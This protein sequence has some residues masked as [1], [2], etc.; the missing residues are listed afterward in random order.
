[1]KERVGSM[2]KNNWKNIWNK[3]EDA[4]D[5]IDSGDARQV[6]LELKRV[7]GFDIAEGGIP[8]EGLLAQYRETKEELGLRE[9]ES[10]FEV[11]CG[12]GAN[13]YLFRR[14]GMRV[15]GLDYSEK[16]IS[17]LQKVLPREE[18]R[19]CICGEAADCPTEIRYDAVFSNSVFSYFP[20]LPYAEK[21]LERMLA[22]SRRSIGL[23]DVHDEVKEKEFRDYR[24]RN[25]ENYEERYR[26]LPKLFY[27]RSFFQD[28]ARKHGLELRFKESKVEGYWN[29]DFIFNCFMERRGEA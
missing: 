27:P 21:V 24:I 14:E 9:G 6:F 5:T 1:M 12:A 23:L 15:G 22:K 8:Y 29:N 25:T 11:G 17:I 20:D 2:P 13:L 16:L 18:L 28:F 26:E 7:D 10:V 3:R 19:E 4:L